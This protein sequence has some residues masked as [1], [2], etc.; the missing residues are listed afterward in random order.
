[1]EFGIAAFKCHSFKSSIVFTTSG[2]YN[3]CQVIL[4]AV[5]CFKAF[6]LPDGA[7]MGREN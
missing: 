3:T 5:F 6:S 1:V 4:R 2:G 7:E